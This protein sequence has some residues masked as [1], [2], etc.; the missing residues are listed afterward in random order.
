M[1]TRVALVSVWYVVAMDRQRKKELPF[2]VDRIRA[3]TLTEEEYLVPDDFTAER[4]RRE[5]MYVDSGEEATVEVRYV[6][7][8][9]KRVR[10]SSSRRD[11]EERPGGQVVRRYRTGPRAGGPDP[12]RGDRAG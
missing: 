9:A 10:E 4:Y 3:A 8:A 11:L 2:R 7:S 5:E 6:G 12:G 1:Q